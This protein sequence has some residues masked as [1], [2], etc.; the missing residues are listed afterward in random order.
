MKKYFAI[1]GLLVL[2]IPLVF[3]NIFD[4]STAAAKDEDNSTKISGLLKLQ[5][6]AKLHALEAKPFEED[7]VDILQAMQAD[8]AEVI[9]LNKQRIFIHASEELSQSQIEELED[10]GLTL[11]LDSWIPPVNN[12][13][14]GFIIADMPKPNF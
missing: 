6:E 9:N 10:M 2:L 1:L 8:G 13:A 14:T 11:Y 12:H 7:H 5:L 3:G 4:T